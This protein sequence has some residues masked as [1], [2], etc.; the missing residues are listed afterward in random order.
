MMRQRIKQRPVFVSMT[1]M[2]QHSGW[3][4]D[5][6]DL[7]V[8]ENDLERDRFRHHRGFSR[9]VGFDL[10]KIADPQ[11]PPAI[12]RDAVD[13]AFFVFDKLA[14]IHLAQI[15]KFFAQV[16]FEPRFGETFFDLKFKSRHLQ[17]A[18]ENAE[19]FE[20]Y[21]EARLTQIIFDP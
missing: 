18:T 17:L 3:F 13:L 16:I 1:R 8:F 5:H 9:R 19:V 2:H 11:A 10:D 20:I 12:F 7:F 6:Q 14:Q 4:V 21:I 15:R